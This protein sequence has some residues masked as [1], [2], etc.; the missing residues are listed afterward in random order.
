[1]KKRPHFKALMTYKTTEDGGIVTPVSSGFRTSLKFPFD[2]RLYMASQTF[3][4]TELVFPGDV[5]SAEITMIN[6][7]TP[8]DKFYEGMDFEFEDQSGTIGSGVITTV[9]PVQG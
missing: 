1:M 4:E 8:S 9:Y 5:I 2:T 7:G 3:S 6:D